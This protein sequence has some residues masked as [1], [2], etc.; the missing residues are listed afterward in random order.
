MAG[1]Y[2]YCN[3]CKRIEKNMTIFICPDCNKPYKTV[4]DDNDI[5]DNNSIEKWYI[6]CRSCGK[7]ISFEDK[8]NI[9]NSCPE[10]YEIGLD[11][12]GE[13]SILSEE[14]YLLEIGETKN[15][16]V[17]KESVPESEE[18]KTDSKETD[19]IENDR[20][21]QLDV[22]E[23]EHIFKNDDEIENVN[24][25]ETADESE[26]HALED[27]YFEKPYG[28]EM[29]SKA[30]GSGIEKI[31]Y[32]EFINNN[33]GKV[34]R[35]SR[36]KHILGKLGDVESEYFS[37]KR[38]I[39]RQHALVAIDDTGAYIEDWDSTN[40]TRI[41]GEPIY[42]RQGKMRIVNEDIVTMADQ[43]FEVRICK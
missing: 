41:N 25:P 24:K 8:D 7:W 34:I 37:E 43:N 20:N 5:E 30:N 36:G 3:S 15:E 9:P 2:Q 19:N 32:I 6:K 22:S 16:I 38:Y 35:I 23:A 21:D 39:G 31:S 12:V 4:S 13:D 26:N 42:K 29:K 10:C 1:G 40:G 28:Q 27:N 14:E 18:K 17:E 33:D 11:N